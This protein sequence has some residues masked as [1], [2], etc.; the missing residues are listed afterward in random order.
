MR[1]SVIVMIIAGVTLLRGQQKQKLT[2]QDIYGSEKFAT[3]AVQK[4]HWL[5]DGSGFTFLEGYA[6]TISGTIYYYDLSTAKKTIALDNFSFKYNGL[7][8]DIGGYEWSPDERYLLISGQNKKIWGSSRESSYY[9]YDTQNDKVVALADENASIQN[10]KISPDGK[11]VGYML[12]NNLYVADIQTAKARALTTDGSGDILNAVFDWVYEEE[13]GS[14]DFAHR[15]LEEKGVAVTPGMDFG[16][17]VPERYLRFA[18][19]MDIELL[20]EGVE[21]IKGFVR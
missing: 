17:N 5:A 12:D 9:I 8:I 6:D 14:A 3:R 16:S 1:L 2:V 10:A 21:R 19:T 18:Y 15:L 13:F 11:S 4:I 7:A 20:R